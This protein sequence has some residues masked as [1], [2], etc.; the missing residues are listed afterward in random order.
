MKK[1]FKT[2]KKYVALFL[3]AL[4]FVGVSLSPLN[5]KAK[6]DY[7]SPWTVV[8]RGPIQSERIMYNGT[9]PMIYKYRVIKYRRTYVNN[10]GKAT[11]LYKTEI[12]KLGLSA[13]PGT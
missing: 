10:S 11:Y 5:Q 6:A 9:K 4:S 3:V 12:Q 13:P 2:Y 7:F 8:S 1:T